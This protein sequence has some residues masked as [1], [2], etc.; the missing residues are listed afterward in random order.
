MIGHDEVPYCPVPV[1]PLQVEDP[2]HPSDLVVIPHFE[3][4]HAVLTHVGEEAVTCRTA[5]QL[6]SQ[7][8]SVRQD[9][10]A[11]E[12]EVV[13]SRTVGRVDCTSSHRSSRR[14]QLS[15]WVFTLEHVPVRMHDLSQEKSVVHHVVHMDCVRSWLPRIEVVRGS[16]NGCVFEGVEVLGRVAHAVDAVPRQMFFH[17]LLHGV[18][19]SPRDL[20]TSSVSCSE[21]GDSGLSVALDAIHPRVMQALVQLS[22]E[23][24]DVHRRYDADTHEGGRVPSHRR[25]GIEHARRVVEVRIDAGVLDGRLES[26][27]ARRI[28]VNT[29]PVTGERVPAKGVLQAKVALQL[30]DEIP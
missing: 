9:Q 8:A 20:W 24:T 28:G 18:Y 10:L 27:H 3:R 21:H 7:D 23:V 22:E 29:Q 1:R 19:V 26:L 16:G 13:D 2:Q 12:I 15:S 4:G 14:V 6:G 30:P 25:L 17:A 11:E 5:W